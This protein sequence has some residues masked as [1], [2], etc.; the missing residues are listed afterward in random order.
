MLIKDLSHLEIINQKLVFSGG[1]GSD[2]LLLSIQDTA[3]ALYLGSQLLFQ[4]TLPTVPTG[5]SVSAIGVSGVAV[6]SSTQT[7]NGTT[8]SL[9]S[10]DFRE[11]SVSD[12][13]FILT[14]TST[15]VPGV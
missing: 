11:V 8:Q 5:I 1:N 13:L 9:V 7:I 3:L 2:G 14:G 12:G 4:T 10:V 15:L 6:S